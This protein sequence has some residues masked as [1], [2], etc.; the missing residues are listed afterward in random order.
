M[1]ARTQIGIVTL[2]TSMR[3]TKLHMTK[4]MHDYALHKSSSAEMFLCNLTT[5]TVYRWACEISPHT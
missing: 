3:G 1:I 5:G 2:S 4:N